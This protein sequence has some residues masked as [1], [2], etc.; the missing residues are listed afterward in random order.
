MDFYYGFYSDEE[1]DRNMPTLLKVL[2]DGTIAED[3]VAGEIQLPTKRAC[4]KITSER[5][6]YQVKHVRSMKMTLC[7][8]TIF[9]PYVLTCLKLQHF[10]ESRRGYL[11]LRC[12]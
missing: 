11:N 10:I 5:Q 12:W 6:L 3:T 9:H 7:D 1:L 2:S 4:V 8:N